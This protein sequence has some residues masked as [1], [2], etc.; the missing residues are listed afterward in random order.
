[1]ANSD[2]ISVSVSSHDSPNEEQYAETLD[3]SP[4]GLVLTIPDHHVSYVE[5]DQVILK[6][7]VDG[8]ESNYSG[9]VISKSEND[10]SLLIRYCTT[11]T[12]QIADDRREG[13]RWICPTNLLPKAVSPSPGRFNEFIEFQI[14]NI[15]RAGIELHT[16]PEAG[17][18][19]TG[20]ILALSI[21]LPLVGSVN[22]AAKILRTTMISV[23]GKDQLSLGSEIVSVSDSDRELIGQFLLQFTDLDSI[24]ELRSPSQTVPKSTEL[25]YVKTSEDF[26]A[27][28]N[29]REIP[30][31]LYNRIAILGSADNPIA[32]ASVTFPARQA[33]SSQQSVRADQIVSIEHLEFN[34]DVSRGLLETFL[35]SVASNSLSIQRPYLQV[36]TGAI[37][38]SMMSKL[39]FKQIAENLYL[40]HPIESLTGGN[41]KL[42]SWDA[43]WHKT[44]DTFLKIDRSLVVGLPKRMLRAYKI[45]API[46]RLL[47][48]S[49]KRKNRL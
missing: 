11:P 28:L 24:D 5:G 32:L 31:D 35:G 18:L 22:L 39:G 25:N 36:K 45:L 13:H 41:T 17:Y 26:L 40:G 20:M 37:S 49:E 21:S 7:T 4:L 43:I 16:G 10:E 12:N 29:Q 30:F 19:V 48:I 3:V 8:E 2:R 42:V 6:I 27:I 14:R 9:V 38:P 23:G 46:A 15:S 1:M 33:I 47:S 44:T 34:S